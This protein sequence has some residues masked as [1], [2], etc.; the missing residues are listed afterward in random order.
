M[1]GPVATVSASLIMLVP[2]CVD[3]YAMVVTTWPRTLTEDE[4]A[5]ILDDQLERFA[6]DGW[7]VLTRTPTTAQ[8]TRPKRISVWAAAFWLLCLVVGLLIYLLVFMARKDPVGRL[9]VPED[10][11]V[12]GI[13]N[14]GDTP[15]P[16]LPGDW[17]CRTCEYPNRREHG[18]CVRCRAPRSL[19]PPVDRTQ[20]AAPPG[21]LSR[22]LRPRGSEAHRPSR[23]HGQASR[24]A[25]GGGG[26]Q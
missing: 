16:R 23:A 21:R 19:S 25:A 12:H 2:A 7:R 6:W 18:V 22:L 3:R 11:R 9:T 20:P 24:L 15:W 4:R 14:D 5:A 17:E 1:K 10:G 13:W 26:S 8:I